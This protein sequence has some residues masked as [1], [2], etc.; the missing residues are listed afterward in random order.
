MGM[1][2]GISIEDNFSV[3][4]CCNIEVSL[5][6]VYVLFLKAMD[7]ANHYCLLATIV[8]LCFLVVFACKISNHFII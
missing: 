4:F 6:P 8:F 1:L 2:H 5:F 7:W 3:I